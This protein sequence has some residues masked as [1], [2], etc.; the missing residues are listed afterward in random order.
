MTQDFLLDTE[1]ALDATM[2]AREHQVAF[3]GMPLDG[4]TTDPVTHLCTGEYRYHL[5]AYLALRDAAGEIRH[6]PGNNRDGHPFA[7]VDRPLIDL[8]REAVEPPAPEPEA[9]RLDFAA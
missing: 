5:D 1:S 9:C 8:L 6:F 7:D 3:Y 4:R 2:L